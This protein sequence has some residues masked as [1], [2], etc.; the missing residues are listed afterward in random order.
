[1]KDPLSPPTR[2]NSVDL[3]RHPENVVVDAIQSSRW[4][5]GSGGKERVIS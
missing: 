1:M 3:D 4:V 5:P 2:K